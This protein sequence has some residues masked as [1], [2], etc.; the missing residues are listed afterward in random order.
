MPNATLVT[1]AGDDHYAYF[2]QADR[3]NRVLEAF[4]KNDYCN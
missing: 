2:H 4:L 1:F 3:F